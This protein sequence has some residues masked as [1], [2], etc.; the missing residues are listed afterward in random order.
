M[1]PMMYASKN[2]E[3]AVKATP[4]IGPLVSDDL[5]TSMNGVRYSIG[6]TADQSEGEKSLVGMCFDIV[7]IAGGK[8]KEQNYP[9]NGKPGVART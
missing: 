7:K 3:T 1:S 6:S 4:V 5:I 2:L 9:S 8:H